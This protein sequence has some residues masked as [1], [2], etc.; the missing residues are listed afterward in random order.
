MF[1]PITK[2]TS[3]LKA[4]ALIAVITIF[5]IIS[6]IRSSKSIDSERIL[7]KLPIMQADDETVELEPTAELPP[8][9]RKSAFSVLKTYVLR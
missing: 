4:I 9:T 2:T 3:K 1:V 8:M 6:M 5:L 7:V